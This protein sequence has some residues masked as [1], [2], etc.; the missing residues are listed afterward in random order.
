MDVKLK[1]KMKKYLMIFALL[2]CFGI[3]AN[4]YTVS[5][6]LCNKYGEVFQLSS[7]G[8]CTFTYQGGWRSGTYDING[9]DI[10]FKWT[11]SNNGAIN[12]S[13][14]GSYYASVKSRF[15]SRIKS[16]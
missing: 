16:S 10:I 9:S 3:S 12:S 15:K 14:N 1:R 4:A 2:V 11:S 8:T 5:R 7:D 13:Q 6:T